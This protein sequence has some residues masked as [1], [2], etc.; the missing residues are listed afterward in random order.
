MCE[1]RLYLAQLAHWPPTHVWH[2]WNFIFI[3]IPNPEIEYSPKMSVNYKI[4][5]VWPY[6]WL[7]FHE[8]QCPQISPWRS[9]LSMTVG[10]LFKICSESLIP[11]TNQNLTGDGRGLGPIRDEGA[12]HGIILIWVFEWQGSYNMSP[13][14]FK[15]FSRTFKGIFPQFSRTKNPKSAAHFHKNDMLITMPMSVAPCKLNWTN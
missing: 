7:Y 1:N 14:K 6:L 10:T 12:S 15:D 2:H 11:L 9:W 8:F 3:F 13:K 5:K 4:K